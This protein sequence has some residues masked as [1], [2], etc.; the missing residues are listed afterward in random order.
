MGVL[1]AK[2]KLYSTYYFHHAHYYASSS[3]KLSAPSRLL[4]ITHMCYEYTTP[5]LSGQLRQPRQDDL[6]VKKYSCC[7]QLSCSYSF[8]AHLLSRSDQWSD[9]QTWC[10]KMTIIEF[11][12]RWL[13]R[14]ALTGSQWECRDKPI[15]CASLCRFCYFLPNCHEQD[16]WSTTFSYLPSDNAS[17]TLLHITQKWLQIASGT[18]Y[19]ATAVNIQ[20]GIQQSF[21]H[22]EDV[23]SYFSQMGWHKKV[24]H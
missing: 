20:H 19:R 15:F 13:S 10:G 6:S 12:F 24:A 11:C 22:A 17:C 18:G 9:C 5:L 1:C 4:D 7:S 8:N 21:G 23:K 14:L 16:V 2:C 3:V